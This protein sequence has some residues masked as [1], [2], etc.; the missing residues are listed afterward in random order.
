MKPIPPGTGPLSPDFTGI[1]PDLMQGF[2][3]ALER[4]RDVIAEQSE[5][6]RQVLTTAQVSALGLQPIK[7]IEGWIDDELPQLRKREQTI[8][9]SDALAKWLPGAGLVPYKEGSRLPVEARRAGTALGERFLAVEGSR[10][11]FGHE[12]SDLY[13]KLLK[14]LAANKD[15]ADFTAAFFAALG[16]KRTLE[17]P[18][19]LRDNVHS[20][21]FQA[22]L[23]PPDPQDPVLRTLSQALGTAVTAGSHV[24]GFAKIKDKIASPSPTER[25]GA[26][27]L[28]SSGKFPAGWLAGVAAAHGL[29]NPGKVGTGV[30]YALGNNPAAARLAMGKAVGPATGDQKKLKDYLKKLNDSTKDNAII[31]EGLRADAVG[32][33]L[34]AASGAYD[35]QG[36]KHSKEAAAF[37][38]TVITTMSGFDIGDAAR[39]H[40][41]EIAGSYATEIVEGAD[42]SD[43][44]MT[45]DS[46]MKPTTSKLGLKSAFTLSPNDTYKFLKTFADTDEHLVPFQTAM[47]EL[48]E[49]L[50]TDTLATTKQTGD[51]RPLDPMLT[52]LGNVRGFELAAAH[53]VQGGLDVLDE[54]QKKL[55][56]FVFNT[57]LG[58]GGLFVPGIPGQLAWLAL[59]TGFSAK[60]AFAA[61]GETREDRLEKAEQN[62]TLGRQHTLA[63]TLMENGFTPKVSPA[64]FQATCPPGV[65]ITDANGNLKPFPELI[66]QGNRGL[67]AFERWAIANGMGGDDELSV[68][69]LSDDMTGWFEGGGTRSKQRALAFDS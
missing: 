54:Q 10:E 14:E 25:S 23:S 41:S 60:D 35:E 20:P 53:K 19:H 56:G 64:E 29:A 37:A 52:A 47:G 22:A 28:L 68:G 45:D 38:F 17:L 36:G 46:S 15:D 34:A 12:T 39:V 16:V 43:A 24:P 26:D 63:Q 51:I 61:D 59:S 32:R 48:S 57:A 40:M 65:A 33:M 18:A 21:R 58:V 2:V 50:I 1:D 67:Q 3:S 66:K 42:I 44:N 11:A 30:L 8:R 69:S 62:A 5:R 4:G 49:R 7:E 31:G 6:I 13:L 55:N 9:A 27:L